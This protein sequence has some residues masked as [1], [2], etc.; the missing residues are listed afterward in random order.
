MEDEFIKV[1]RNETV[2]NVVKKMMDVKKCNVTDDTSMC[3]PILA[4]YV[5]EDNIPIGVVYK[6]TII[7][8]IILSGEDPKGLSIESIMEPPTCMSDNS[9]VKDVVNL[10]LDKGL[11]VVAIVDGQE[12][13]SV[14]SVFDAIYLKDSIATE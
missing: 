1:E 5:M 4:A 10:I 6:D 8:K 11:M 9:Q 3:S 2:Y 7:E 12:L 13:V 14:I